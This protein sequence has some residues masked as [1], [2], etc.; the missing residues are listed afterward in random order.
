MIYGFPIVVECYT[1][2][3]V[4]HECCLRIESGPS[5]FDIESHIHVG[6]QAVFIFVRVI[7]VFVCHSQL[8]C[9]QKGRTTSN[10]QKTCCKSSKD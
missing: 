2:E 4:H 9:A 6:V 10:S 3:G 5:F 7:F 1:V 8:L